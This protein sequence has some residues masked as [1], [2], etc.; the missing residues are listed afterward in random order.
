MLLQCSPDAHRR[1]KDLIDAVSGRPASTR[2]WPTTWRAASP[3]P[4]PRRHGKEG[5]A[6]FLEKRAPSVAGLTSRPRP[7]GRGRDMNKTR[8]A[9]ARRVA[10]ADMNKTSSR[11]RPKGRGRVTWR[12]TLLKLAVGIDGVDHLRTVQA[13][14][15]AADSAA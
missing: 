10:G 4:A 7:K 5:I 14:R 13:A 9:R 15:L 12:C 8:V 11:P 2:R 1:A 3:P 6:A